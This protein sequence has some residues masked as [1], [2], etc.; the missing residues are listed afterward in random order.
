M[1]KDLERINAYTFRGDDRE[2]YEVMKA[3]GFNPPA[4]RTDDRYLEI[5]SIS[6]S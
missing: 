5:A 3:G 1:A 2:P 4:S 6:Y